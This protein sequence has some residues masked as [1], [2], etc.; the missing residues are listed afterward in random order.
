MGHM[1][2]SQSLEPIAALNMP[3]CSYLHLN[4]TNPI[5]RP[6]SAEPRAVEAAGLFVAE[7]GQE[8]TL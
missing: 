2:V 3:A 4:N 7:D 5:L 1:P 6:D 8:F